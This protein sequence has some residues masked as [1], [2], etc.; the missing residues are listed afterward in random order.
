MVIDP[1]IYEKV[2]KGQKQCL[3]CRNKASHSTEHGG[4]CYFLLRKLRI[5][6]MGQYGGEIHEWK[7]GTD[8]SPK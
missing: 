2:Y 8:V 5:Q 1:A 6:K 7:C 3:S 4:L